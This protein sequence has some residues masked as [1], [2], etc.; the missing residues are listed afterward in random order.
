M[1]TIVIKEGT[2][3][4]NIRYEPLII[5]HMELVRQQ[6]VGEIQRDFVLDKA[7]FGIPDCYTGKQD[8]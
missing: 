3:Q 7:N 6:N 4:T 2:W 1:T 5:E 8:L